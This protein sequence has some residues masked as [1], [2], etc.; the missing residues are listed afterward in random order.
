MFRNIRGRNKES[1]L[2]VLVVKSIGKNPAIKA[3]NR[4]ATLFLVMCL[5]IRK[6]IIVNE[7]KKRL[8]NILAISSRGRNRLKE[9]IK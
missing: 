7:V 1:T 2:S 8:G 4:A 3:E 6:T 9:A 5:L